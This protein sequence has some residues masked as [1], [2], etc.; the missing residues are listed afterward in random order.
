MD[1]EMMSNISVFQIYFTRKN[2]HKNIF[3]LVNIYSKLSYW[4]EM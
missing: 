3:F 1:D 4:H 2:K